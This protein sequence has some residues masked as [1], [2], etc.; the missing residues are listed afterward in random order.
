MNL[1]EHGSLTTMNL[2]AIMRNDSWN[3]RIFVNNLTDEDTPQN[4]AIGNFYA[5]NPNPA[6]AAIAT[7]S[8]RVVQRRPREIG[9]VLTYNFGG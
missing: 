2:S 6:N 9:A 4:V 3:F 7:G 5:P 1:Q 8:W